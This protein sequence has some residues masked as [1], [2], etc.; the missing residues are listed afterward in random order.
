MPF[1]F[2]DFDNNKGFANC[3]YTYIKEVY[4]GL[5]NSD[6]DLSMLDKVSNKASDG[7]VYD[8]GQ[9]STPLQ[10]YVVDDGSICCST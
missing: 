5:F 3:S 10:P 4:T 8:D 9:E 1:N 6:K 7:Q 2:N